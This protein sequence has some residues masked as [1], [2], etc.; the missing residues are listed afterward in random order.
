MES[1]KL[2]Q[3]KIFCKCGR[4]T[5]NLNHVLSCKKS[6]G[7]F[8]RHDSQVEVLN[9][10]LREAGVVARKEVRVIGGTQKR[11]DIVITLPSGERMW[12]DVS[13]VNPEAPTYA[14]KATPATELRAAEKVAKWGHLAREQGIQFIPAI[15]DVYGNMGAG[16]ESLLQFIADKAFWVAPFQHQLKGQAWK[17]NYVSGLRQR[18]STSLAYCNF[19]MVEESCIGAQ[20]GPWSGLSQHCRNAI[21][22]MYCGLK[23]FTSYNR[24]RI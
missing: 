7:R 15:I 3:G 5:T 11:M 9:T 10:M 8:V 12:I 24:S 21:T 17:G 23:R 19:L 20:A 16:Y 6:R 2:Q 1:N 13:V 14:S 22:K 18:L 4:D